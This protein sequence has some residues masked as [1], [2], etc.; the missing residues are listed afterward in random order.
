[1]REMNVPKNH[2]KRKNIMGF[3]YFPASF[4]AQ[5]QK[6]KIQNTNK[7]ISIYACKYIFLYTRTFFDKFIGVTSFQLLSFYFKDWLL[8]FGSRI[9]LIFPIFSKNK[10]LWFITYMKQRCWIQWLECKCGWPFLHH[11]LAG[12]F[13]AMVTGLPVKYQ[14]GPKT[15][16]LFYI[17]ALCFIPSPIVP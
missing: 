4:T 14:L 13:H 6:I 5:K 11:I 17:S 1:M 7:E 12:K 10:K 9:Y 2:Q 3:Y 8:F 15:L 16:N